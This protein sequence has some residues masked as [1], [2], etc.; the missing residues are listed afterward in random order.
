M[1]AA[2]QQLGFAIRAVNEAQRAMREIQDNLG[3]VEQAAVEAS[4]EMGSFRD[5]LY[6]IGEA[7]G[8]AEQGMRGLSDLMIVLDEQFGISLGPMQ[9]WTSAA[10]DIGGGIEGVT[11]GFPALFESLKA[12]PGSLLPVIAAT[13]AH[14]TALSAQA[15]AFIAAN[16]PMLLLIG[17]LALLV[18][19]VV[20]VV[21]HWDEIV[22]KFPALG[23]AVDGVKSRLD[24]A[25][26]WVKN[27]FIP[28]VAGIYTGVK[29]AVEDA[30]A[31]VRDHWDEIR[32]II[33]PALQALGVVIDTYWKQFK[34]TIETVFGVIK[35]VVDVAMGIFT[36]DWERAWG[37][38]K[39][40]FDSLWNGLKGTVENALGL[41]KGL[42][43]IA[44]DA[45]KA[46]GEAVKDGFIAGVKGT[47]GVIGNLKDALLDA[48]KSLINSAIDQVN[49]AIPNDLSISVLGK[50]IG[51]DLPDNP[52]PKLATGGIVRQPTLA[53]IGE[54]GPEAVV[55][56]SGPNAPRGG[57]LGGVTI[58]IN[59]PV[60]GVDDLIYT[61]DRALK[62]AGQEGLVA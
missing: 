44:L 42:A 34:T 35:G 38:V 13:W 11:K 1:S 2:N 37:G 36:G 14:V 5:K 52:I 9:E 6:N 16:A 53:L 50:T 23:T 54:A 43:P 32:A 31:F 39:Q 18:A 22:A 7:G 17:G 29:D 8:S 49:D 30:I 12:I 55:P 41:V 26:E 25:V 61:I 45:A 58:N 4:M 46:V 33:E 51:I 15:A 62:R 59:A 57:G 10:A 56:L 28:G 19:G 21:K 48:L 27:V 24:A 20:L 3:E 40:I 47:I 60:Y